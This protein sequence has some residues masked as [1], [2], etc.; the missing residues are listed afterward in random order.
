MWYIYKELYTGSKSAREDIIKTFYNDLHNKYINNFNSKDN[1]DFEVKIR[2]YY[3][4]SASK[5]NDN[6]KLL[7]SLLDK[8]L[9]DDYVKLLENLNKEHKEKKFCNIEKG[10]INYLIIDASILETKIREKENNNK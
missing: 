8:K 2:D 3:K 6:E 10:I 7:K 5:D 4:D 1:S 9:V